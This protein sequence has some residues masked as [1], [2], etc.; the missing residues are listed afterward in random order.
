MATREYELGEP[1]DL[2][3][4][5]KRAYKAIMTH[6]ESQESLDF[7]F[8][9][10]GCKTF[11]SPREWKERGELYGT[12]SVLVVVYDGGDVSMFFNT[13]KEQ[14]RLYTGMY[15]ALK[16]AGFYTEEATGWQSSI[17]EL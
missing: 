1:Q 11:Y 2:D 14:V 16:A 7:K 8:E 17:Y 10:G 9:T 5:G 6:L 4:R 15:E 12:S 3:D 13:D